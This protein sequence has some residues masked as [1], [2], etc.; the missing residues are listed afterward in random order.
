M[1]LPLRD[2]GLDGHIGQFFVEIYDLI[3]P[4]KIEQDAGAGPQEPAIHS[5]DSC[6]C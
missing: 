5:P 6:R 1:K 2:A 4:A 3:H